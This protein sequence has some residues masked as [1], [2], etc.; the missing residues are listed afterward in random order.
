M[1]IKNVFA[2]VAIQDIADAVQWY[3]MLLG[4]DPDT[5]PMDGLNTITTLDRPLRSTIVEQCL[6]ESSRSRSCEVRLP[7]RGSHR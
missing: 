1:A 2:G 5:Q 7:P 4:R 3:K 6:R